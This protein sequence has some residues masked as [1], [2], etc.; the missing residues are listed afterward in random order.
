MTPAE[1]VVGRRL[2]DPPRHIDLFLVRFI[3]RDGLF[4][5]Q[6]EPQEPGPREAHMDAVRLGYIKAGVTR[7]TSPHADGPMWYLTHDGKVAAMVAQKTISAIKRSRQ[8]WAADLRR[9]FGAEC[10]RVDLMVGNVVPFRR[11]L[12]LSN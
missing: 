1:E 2:P 5:G 12:R 10:E 9:V 11:P 3:R 7:S 8:E 6:P 4:C